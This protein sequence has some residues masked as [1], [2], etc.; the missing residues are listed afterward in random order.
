MAAGASDMQYG[1]VS[2]AEALHS[3]LLLNGSNG[4][5]L[6]TS[7]QDSIVNSPS[8]QSLPALEITGD[9]KPSIFSDAK[10]A[11]PD[12]WNGAK[13]EVMNHPWQVAKSFGEG[14]AEGAVATAAVVGIAT[15]SAPLAIAAV[16]V[17][18]AVG[19]YEAGSALT[20]W[21]SAGSTLENPEATSAQTQAAHD[22]L[23]AGGHAL[24]DTTANVIGGIA[25]AGVASF[26]INALTAAAARGALGS[27]ADSATPITPDATAPIAQASAG[28]VKN[29]ALNFS[30]TV[31]AQTSEQFPN[32]TGADRSF[33]EFLTAQATGSGYSDTALW[34]T[35]HLSDPEQIGQFADLYAKNAPLAIKNMAFKVD[36]GDVA[37]GTDSAWNIALSHVSAQ[38]GDQSGASWYAA[39]AKS[40]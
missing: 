24:A 37:D 32:A 27:I 10:A 5:S 13:D 30:A 3:S 18:G 19:V 35:Q 9:T 31:Q 22:T 11:L 33:A 14:I 15:L 2:K 29:P 36:S 1:E 26:G 40:N 12:L 16:G 6:L 23:N 38:A 25:G 7:R 8:S 39:A 34:A 4:Q 17:V 20:K 28:A 21:V